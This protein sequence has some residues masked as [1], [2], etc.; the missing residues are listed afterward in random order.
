MNAA[1]MVL[2]VLLEG[3]VANFNVAEIPNK[4]IPFII[5]GVTNNSLTHLYKCITLIM[6]ICIGVRDSS[7]L[8]SIPVL[9]SSMDT[10]LYSGFDIWIHGCHSNLCTVLCLSNP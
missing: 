7:E 8:Q 1:I 6:Y 9:L 5:Q 3:F 10:I 2:H 4:E